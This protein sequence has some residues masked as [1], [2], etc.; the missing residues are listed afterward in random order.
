M[1]PRP[2]THLAGGANGWFAALIRW[3]LENYAKLLRKTE[4]DVE[5]EEL[6]ARGKAIRARHAEKNP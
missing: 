1:R 3:P 6:E 5:A 4:R 2:F